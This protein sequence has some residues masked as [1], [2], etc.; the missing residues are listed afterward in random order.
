MQPPKGLSKVKAVGLAAVIGSIAAL[1]AIFG[2]P[3]MKGDSD[4][5]IGDQTTKKT[6]T[7]Q[8]YTE[9]ITQTEDKKPTK[10][11][12]NIKPGQ[13]LDNK[14]AIISLGKPGSYDI[15][16]TDQYCI[17]IP[18]LSSA[19]VN[20]YN[21][22]DGTLEARTEVPVV[23][24]QKVE[25]DYSSTCDVISSFTSFASELKQQTGSRGD[26][27]MYIVMRGSIPTAEYNGKPTIM[28]PYNTNT[29]VAAVV[30]NL[31]STLNTNYLLYGDKA[32]KEHNLT[33][34]PYS[35]C[36]RTWGKLGPVYY[37]IKYINSIS[38]RHLQPVG[39]EPL[40][41]SNKYATNGYKSIVLIGAAKST[42]EKADEIG[43]T[44]KVPVYNFVKPYLQ[45]GG[46]VYSITLYPY[47]M[48]YMSANEAILGDI[49]SGKGIVGR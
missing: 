33:F 21:R 14:I 34:I 12:P 23:L 43:C 26:F 7:V 13:K 2:G 47:D 24:I 3:L 44:K 15:K 49:A 39:I 27:N 48:N 9:T 11:T 42:G 41:F 5:Y 22:R 1:G 31:T 40:G 28:V 35:S 30:S 25:K 8:T 38:A 4:K 19:E 46:I 20:I 45:N 29:Q 10:T 6:T 16:E 17:I 36:E 18:N 37:T 32:L